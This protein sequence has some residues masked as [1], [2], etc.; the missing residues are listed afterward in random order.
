MRREITRIVTPG[1]ATE[2]NLLRSHENNY[3]A[4]VASERR[5]R[6]PGAR[7]CLHRRVSR[8]GTRSAEVAAAL[9][10]LNAREVLIPE[11]ARRRR[12][13][14]CGP[15]L[16]DWIFDLDYAERTLREHF[17]L[18]SLDGC[19]LEGRPLAVGAAGAVLHY[20]RDTQ[21][22]R[23]RSSGP[24]RLTTIARDA[25][26]LDAVTVRN[27]ELVEPLFAGESRE[28]TL[29]NVLDQTCTGMGGRLLAPPAAAA[30]ASN[31]TEIEA[32]LDAVA[33]MLAQT[34]ERAE[35]RKTLGG[36]LDLERLLA[37]MT[38]RHGGPAGSAGA[39]PVAGAD[40]RAASS[41]RGEVRRGCGELAA[42]LDPVAEVT[43]R[44]L[45]RDRR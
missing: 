35:I 45:D 30:I 40:S 44:I 11:Q 6:R 24:A 27:L 18:L 37:K 25:M 20:L 4:A 33:Q 39:R 2:S 12:R 22:S 29:I 38:H 1:T 13:R 41:A 8:H 9:E 28:S 7:R 43:R 14:A 32:R 34:I 21:R 26:M 23:A 3:L 16:E 17:K 31:W 5:A 19:G 15:T 10:N 36:M 42:R